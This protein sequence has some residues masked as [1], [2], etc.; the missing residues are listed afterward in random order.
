[1]NELGEGP[2]TY[3]Y[4]NYDDSLPEDVELPIPEA[5]PTA[6]GETT[7][8]LVVEAEVG[9]GEENEETLTP[10]QLVVVTEEGHVEETK[11]K[12]EKKA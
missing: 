7:A 4:W 1:L 10:I 5:T 11:P 6:L 2:C 3:C 9:Q 12:K 8:P